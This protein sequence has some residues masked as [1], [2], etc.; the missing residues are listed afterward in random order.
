MTQTNLPILYLR[1]VVLLPFNDT[2]LEFSSDNDKKILNIA[3][4]NYD[5]YVLLINLNDPLEEEPDYNT[6]PDI[7]ILGKIKSKI[8]LPNGITRVVMTGIDRVEI[9]SINNNNDFLNISMI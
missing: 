1:D 2:R 4:S 3:E 8:D 5:G 9:V 6:L 7:G